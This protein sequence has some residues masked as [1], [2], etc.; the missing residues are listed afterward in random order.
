MSNKFATQAEKISE[1]KRLEPTVD[2]NKEFI[3]GTPIA[4]VKFEID[5]EKSKEYPN[6]KLSFKGLNEKNA[7]FLTDIIFGNNFDEK[8]KYYN[9]NKEEGIIN[10]ITQFLQAYIPNDKFKEGLNIVTELVS[11]GDNDWIALLKAFFSDNSYFKTEFAKTLK[12]EAAIILQRNEKGYEIK[13]DKFA[14]VFSTELLP[15]IIRLKIDDKWTKYK[16]VEADPEP[17][18][19]FISLPPLPEGDDLPL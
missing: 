10:Y 2:Q 3:L 13:K 8:H 15:Q 18:E 6:L 9:K 11:K 4:F 12:G 1:G 14:K 5:S 7:G 19:D 16:P 17:E